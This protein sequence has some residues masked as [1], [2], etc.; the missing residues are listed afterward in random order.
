MFEKLYVRKWSPRDWVL[1]TIF[2]AIALTGIVVGYVN[3]QRDD[4]TG[5]I[6]GFTKQDGTPTHPYLNASQCPLSTD[7]IFWPDGPSTPSM[8]ADISVCFVRKVAD[9]RQR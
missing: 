6:A 7:L 1:F 4:V 2:A 3:D 8:P 5:S 9:Q